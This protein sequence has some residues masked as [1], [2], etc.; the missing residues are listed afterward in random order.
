MSTRP[1][2]PQSFYWHDYETTGISQWYDRPVQFGG[3]RTDAE[4][5]PLAEPLELYCRPSMDMLPDPGA[6]LVTG[7]TPQTARE[8]GLAEHLFS[9]R[10]HQELSAP[11]TCA[12][13][14]N[15]IRFD[16]G[17]TRHMLYRNFYDPYAR[18]WQNGN[19]RWDLLDT[20]RLC[21][22]LRPADIQWPQNE[23]GELSFRLEDL[24][25]ANGID[26]DHAHDAVTDARM[27]LELARLVRTRQQRLFDYAL[28][29]RDRR[30]AAALLE[31]SIGKQAVMHVS[32]FYGNSRCCTAMV[33]PLLQAPEEK[34]SVVAFDLNADP[35]PL[36]DA[37]DD[38][39]QKLLAE[40][41]PK[42]LGLCRIDL[43]K[44]SLFA[45]LATLDAAGEERI[46]IDRALCKKR[47]G[48]LQAGMK[49]IGPR[50]AQIMSRTAQ[51]E[52]CKDPERL[53][54]GGGFL[55]DGDRA[56][57]EEVRASAPEQLAAREFDFRD[58]RMPELLFRY[59]ARN[60][61]ETLD[62][63]ERARWEEYR[64]Q[65]LTELDGGGLL[66]LDDYLAKIAMLQEQ[67]QLNDN[68]RKVLQALEAW[69][70]EVVADS[71]A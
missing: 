30:Y 64:Y 57:C 31:P 40:E 56:L 1:P 12:V 15:S 53:L 63:Q 38:E 13:G 50:A 59:R 23:E 28:A 22:A 54:Y 68:D 32:H 65:R 9:A 67:P 49:R 43:H 46:G 14:F 7:I 8:K 3:V 4:L 55:G 2:S 52:P 18:E 60:F 58:Q 17:F 48:Q 24:A 20:L 39:L 34:W 29:L 37:A 33:L 6:C 71:S 45:P 16:D 47:L 26:A 69:V 70:D 21:R 61:P 25:R 44:C 62:T 36:F 11:G 35:A 19:S 41:G 66:L 27:T 51:D 5:N 10:V 42:A